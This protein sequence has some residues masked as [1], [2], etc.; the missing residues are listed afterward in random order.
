[1]AVYVDDL[2]HYPTT[3]LREK[4]WCHMLADTSEELDQVAAQI[5][6]KASWKQHPSRPT[7]HYDLTPSKR[8]A[9]I[10]AGAIQKS[11]R[12]IA[13]DLTLPRLRA[14]AAK[15]ENGSAGGA[16]QSGA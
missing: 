9:A 16:A 2:K 11:S 14:L 8:A 4:T 7:E 15:E 10:R 6:L 12:E 5:G 3:S 13:R 1:M